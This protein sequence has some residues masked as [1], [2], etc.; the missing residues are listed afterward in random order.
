MSVIYSIS[1]HVKL[2]SRRGKARFNLQPWNELYVDL[3]RLSN[4]VEKDAIGSSTILYQLSILQLLLLPE[5][6]IIRL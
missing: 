3:P 2:G 5:K 4:A 6:V 1:Y